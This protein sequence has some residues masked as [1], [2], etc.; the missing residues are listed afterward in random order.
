MKSAKL[1]ELYVCATPIAGITSTNGKVVTA[2]YFD[3]GFTI[4][5]VEMQNRA[6]SLEVERFLGNHLYVD[7]TGDGKTVKLWSGTPDAQLSPRAQVA[8][9]D[10]TD[11]S[12]M[13]YLQNG[14]KELSIVDL[15]AILNGHA[16]PEPQVFG[17]TSD[18]IEYFTRLKSGE[19]VTIENYENTQLGVYDIA[20]SG[21]MIAIGKVPLAGFKAI[22]KNSKDA[23]VATFMYGLAEHEGELLIMPDQR[24]NVTAGIYALSLDNGIEAALEDK[25]AL[26]MKIPG[27]NGTGIAP[28]DGG[29]LISTYAYDRT[30]P[31]FGGPSKILYLKD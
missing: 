20:P 5:S 1:I 23:E 16:V 31:D 13:L 11:T 27:I 8:Q 14:A 4:N 30:K 18:M 6:P 3:P 26:Q 21:E 29:L 9:I 25:K 10:P 19:I 15:E 12:K 22:Q 28:I 17:D 7:Q 24:S 2:Q